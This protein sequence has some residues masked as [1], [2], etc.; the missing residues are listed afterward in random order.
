[1]NKETKRI[2][3]FI[4]FGV[5]LF[6]LCMNLGAVL[7]FL[8]NVVEIIFPIILGLLIAFVLNVPMKGM[9]K[10]LVRMFYKGKRPDKTRLLSGISLL[11]TLICILLIVTL[12]LTM[13][14]PALVD[15]TK[16]VYPLIKEKW[17]ELS[18]RLKEHQIDISLLNDWIASLDAVKLSNGAGA[19]WNS[20]TTTISSITSAVFGTIIAIYGLLSKQKL[21]L[22]LK[23]LLYANLPNETA[24][25]ICRIGTITQDTYA[26][27][28]SGQC[29]EAILLGGLI[30]IAF[31]LFH[32]PYAA[33]IGF[34]TGICAFVP[35]VGA[36]ISFAIGAFLTLLIDPSR[37]LICIIVYLAVQFT[38]NQFIYPH[39]VGGSV[40]LAPV[41]TLVA[42][43]IGGKIFGLPGIVFFIP[44]AAVTYILVRE[45]T[46]RKLE[47]KNIHVIDVH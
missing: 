41:F 46:N 15:S 25:G 2:L 27:F 8:Q 35:Y 18:A 22:H 38:E 39:V 32:L 45:S 47:D 37:V 19:I 28:L 13:A 34:L 23:K 40:G 6:A 20:A 16:S 30:F 21:K 43:L 11:L 24:E 5:V 10:L 9:E 29:I 14:I 31:S 3:G 1:M 26:K 7:K 17:P 12:A 44:L 36:F 4:A 33:L 42:A